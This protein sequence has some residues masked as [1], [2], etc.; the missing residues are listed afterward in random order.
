MKNMGNKTKRLLITGC[1]AVVC[2]FLIAAIVSRF[3][4]ETDKVEAISPSNTS[5]TD[6]VKPD[7]HTENAE[8]KDEVEVKEIN[9]D[10]SQ[11]DPVSSETKEDIVNPTDP[12]D[13]QGETSQSNEVVQTNVPEATKPEVPEK[14]T[15]QGDTTNPEKQP[16]YKPED[17]IIAKPSTKPSEPKAGDKNE[18]GQIWFPG[19]GWI[20]DEGGGS[21]GEEVGSDGDIN[22]QVGSMD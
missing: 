17:T 1:L 19:F 20:D 6:M 2:V 16:E 5:E 12:C 3:N 18:K 22:K 13:Q 21:Q 9:P 14:P 11:S 8:K 7:E 10:I 4:T 15:P